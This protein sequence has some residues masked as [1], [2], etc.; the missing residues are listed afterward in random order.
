MNHLN[1]FIA[2]QQLPQNYLAL[3]EQWYKPLATAIS[4]QTQS[5]QTPLLVAINGCQGSGKSTLAEY[6]ATVLHH[7]YQLSA[8]ILSIDDF[9]LTLDERRKL[10]TDIHPL[11]QTRGVPGTHDTGLLHQVLTELSQKHGSASIPRFDKAMDDRHDRQQWSQ[12][13]LPL[14]VIILEGWCMG[15]PAQDDAHLQQP[16]NELEKQEDPNGTWRHYVNRQLQDHYQPIFEQFDLWIMLK[17]PSFDNV[18][19]WRLQQE[20]KLAAQKQ[21]AQNTRIMDDAEIRRFIQ[22]YQ[23]LTESCLNNLSTSVHFLYELDHERLPQNL[24]H[25]LS[26]PLPYPADS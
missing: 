20:Q 19:Q 5:R 13:Q 15:A 22:H 21:P 7:E 6:L 14:D 23:R 1:D 10:A 25:P 9:Y 12:M 4:Q 17:A 18:F 8:A 2:Q 24:S 26:P 11:L 3:A 16:C